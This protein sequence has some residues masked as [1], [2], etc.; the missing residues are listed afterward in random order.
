MEYVEAQYKRTLSPDTSD[1]EIISMLSGGGG[2]QVDVVFYVILGSML[3]SSYIIFH[4]Y[5]NIETGLKPVD[6]EYLRRLSQLT[7]VVPIVAQSEGFSSDKLQE[8][9][10]HV[11]CELQAANVR[12]FLLGLNSQDGL[13]ESQPQPPYAVSTILTN[14]DE[15]MDASLLM[16]PDYVQPLIPTEL[17]TLVSQVFNHDTISWLRHSAAKK[18]LQYHRGSPSSSQHLRSIPQSIFGRPSNILTTPLGS[19]NTY[20]LARIADHTQREEQLAQVRLSK[21]AA[22]LQRS[23]QNER[24]RFEALAKGERAVWLTERLG[25]CV[26][27]GTLIPISAADADARLRGI[28]SS[29]SLGAL[30]GKGG[31]RTRGVRGGRE[32]GLDRRDPL[33]LLRFNKEVKEGALLVLRVVG[34]CSAIGGLVF[35]LVRS[36]TAYVEGQEVVWWGREWGRALVD[37]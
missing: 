31:F 14:E 13:S 24:A 16:S 10:E 30:V 37:W 27:D 23:L 15:I 2:S 3:T 11:R 26:A 32:R 12:P 35:W 4:V 33:G 20:A 17:T 9:K 25:E 34:G 7:N 28:E 1:P 18:C 21:W 8:I 6:I 5:T 22:D 36:Y 29:E 19:T